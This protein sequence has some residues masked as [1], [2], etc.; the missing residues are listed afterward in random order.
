MPLSAVS[1]E[2]FIV[3]YEGQDL[4]PDSLGLFVSRKVPGTRD[5][6]TLNVV[7]ACFSEALGMLVKVSTFAFAA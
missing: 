2:R 4:L 3:I 5:S 1:D 6:G 7:D